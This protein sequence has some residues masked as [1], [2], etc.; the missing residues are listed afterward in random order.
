LIQQNQ[1]LVQAAAIPQRDK[2]RYNTINGL[3]FNTAYKYANDTAMETQLRQTYAVWKK[4]DDRQT[5]S[6]HIPYDHFRFPIES[7]VRQATGKWYRYHIHYNP[8]PFIARLRIPVLAIYG[9]KDVMV[10]ATTS[11]ANWKK[12]ASPAEQGNITTQIFPGLNHLLQHCQTCTPAEYAQLK[13]TIAPE[14]LEAI[15][16]WMKS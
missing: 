5:D 14:V 7:Y 1:Q 2:D 4:H 10:N 11:V 13:E 3:M 12:F 8:A 6:L 16:N 15:I 9:D